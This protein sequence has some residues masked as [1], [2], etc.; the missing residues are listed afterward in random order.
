LKIWTKTIVCFDHWFESRSRNP[1]L[2]RLH[3]SV[4]KSVMNYWPFFLEYS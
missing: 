1:L 3:F 4:R 2:K